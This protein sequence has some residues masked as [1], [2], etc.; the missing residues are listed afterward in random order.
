MDASSLLKRINPK[1]CCSSFYR[2]YSRHALAAGISDSAGSAVEQPAHDDA[3]IRNRAE[4]DSPE[5]GS[6]FEELLDLHITAEIEDWFWTEVIHPLIRIYHD[7]QDA[8]YHNISGENDRSRTAL[9]M[10]RI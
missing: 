1:S 10:T 2:P 7:R 5:Q 8:Q 6:L 9:S 4:S 3:G